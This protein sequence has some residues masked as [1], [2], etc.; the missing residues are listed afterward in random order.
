M[1]PDATNNGVPPGIDPF[2]RENGRVGLTS[3]HRL[4]L[5]G[6]E[7]HHHGLHLLQLL[8]VATGVFEALRERFV[9]AF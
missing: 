6:G 3:R 1:H 8:L 5:G 7:L 2:G 4:G 9:L